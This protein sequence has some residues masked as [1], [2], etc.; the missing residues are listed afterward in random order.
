MQ[1]SAD[2]VCSVINSVVHMGTQPNVMAQLVWLKQLVCYMLNI[3][4]K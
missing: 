1:Y 3:D 2:I 4:G